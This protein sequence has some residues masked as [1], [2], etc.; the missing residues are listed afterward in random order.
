MINQTF[1]DL[2]GKLESV[3]SKS[4]LERYKTG[5]KT[6]TSVYDSI[7]IAA[8]SNSL[9]F[10]K[11]V[12]GKSNPTRTNLSQNRLDNG[13]MLIITSISLATFTEASVGAVPAAFSNITQTLVGLLGGVLTLNISSANKIE[14]Y[15]ILNMLPDLN[16]K[17]AG[18]AGIGAGT[19]AATTIR[20]G[21]TIMRLDTPLVLDANQDFYASVR[22]N[23]FTAL[24]DG[25]IR[26]SLNGLGV[27]PN[28]RIS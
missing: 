3:L 10:F 6:S 24:A 7:S 5:Q 12:S 8:S 25:F 17:A 19:S 28:A 15:P 14:D 9:D 11:N 2:I 23:G 20:L 1:D 13:K 21:D 18:Y 27:L 26:M 16:P 4:Q 22:S